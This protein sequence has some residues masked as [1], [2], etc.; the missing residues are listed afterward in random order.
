MSQNML[1]VSVEQDRI[2]AVVAKRWGQCTATGALVP[3]GHIGGDAL[4]R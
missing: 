3:W 1:V 4:D 2:E